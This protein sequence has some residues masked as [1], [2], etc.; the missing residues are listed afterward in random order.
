[1]SIRRPRRATH[2]P[3][4]F[5]FARSRRLDERASPLLTVHRTGA[6]CRRAD[7]FAETNMSAIDDGSIVA[8]LR[9]QMTI[10]VAKQVVAAGNLANVDTPGF[11]ARELDFDR[12]LDQELS[13]GARLT[14]TNARHILS[15]P[16]A[17][18]AATREAPNLNARRDGNTVQL[19]REL[20]TMTEASGEFARAQTALAAKFRLVRYA[21]NEGR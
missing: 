8:A 17:M 11:R 20:M 1:M 5:G 12:A 16:E 13:G 10:A 15:A 3:Q 2:S 4:T 9:R 18:A 14:A 7:P 21:I 19:D 6:P